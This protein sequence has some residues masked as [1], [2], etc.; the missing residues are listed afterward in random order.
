MEIIRFYRFVI[1]SILIQQS[2]TIGHQENIHTEVIDSRHE[3]IGQN[4]TL[5]ENISKPTLS[6]SKRQFVFGYD[7]YYYERFRARGTV[8]FNAA[9]AKRR[10]CI[11]VRT[12]ECG[13]EGG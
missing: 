13:E 11:R 7:P 9:Q 4:F 10:V 1:W 3:K 5:I 2:T 12:A 8:R 6:R